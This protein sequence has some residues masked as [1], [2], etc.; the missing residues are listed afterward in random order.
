VLVITLGAPSGWAG[1][2]Q[3]IQK[4]GS[5]AGAID[6]A[7]A[8]LFDLRLSGP[9]REDAKGLLSYLFSDGGIN[10]RLSATPLLAP[11]L[12]SR[13]HR[14][15]ASQASSIE[16]GYF[17]GFVTADGRRFTPAAGARDKT[18][19][20]L[21][22]G[23]SEVP[24][25]AL[26]LQAAGKGFIVAEG[27]AGDASVVTTSRLSLGEG[28]EAQVRLTELIYE[29]GS[30]GFQ[31]DR[32]LPA[33][34]LQGQESEGFRA[35]LELAL[36]PRPA[37]RGRSRVPVSTASRFDEAYPEPTFPPL[38]YRLLAAFR[39]HNIIGYFFPYKDLMGEDWDSVLKDFIPR[40]EQA[41]DATEYHL[42]V[43]EM[44]THVHDSHGFVASRV[45][46]DYFGAARPPVVAR[47]IED[48]PV[49]A[50]FLDERA[51][52]QAGAKIGD[53]ILKVDGEDAKDRLARIGRYTDAST[54]QYR[55]QVAARRLMDGPEGSTAVVTIRD[56]KDH[57]KEIRLPRQG[58]YYYQGGGWRRGPVLRVLPGNI[59]YADLDRLEESEVDGMFEKFRRTRAIIFDDRG[60]PKGTAWAIAPRLTQASEVVAA[61]FDRPL[62]LEPEGATGDV[63]G[64]AARDLFLQTLP[65]TDKWR[66]RGR[67]V[68]LIDERTIS[69]AEHTGL[70][71]EA[72]NGTKFVGSPTAGAN[73]DVTNFTVPGGITINFSGQGVRHADG[74]QL[75]R[76][77]LVPDLE[78]RPT[79]AGI[80]AG[81]DEVL[82]RALAYVKDDLR[83][84]AESGGKDPP[85]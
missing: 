84:S 62:V 74:R 80:R 48:V 51:A 12:R 59:G 17:S 1:F 82:E 19:V 11:G 50:L 55:M 61:R 13:M 33:P 70:F 38:E 8:V 4:V 5:L 72:A 44:M 2:V 52:R 64:Q 18:T 69:Q 15:F 60:Y 67:T 27:S 83:S 10:G 20:F 77:G 54:P 76:I 14:G 34:R 24:P 73:G 68:L 39:I 47:M 42:A 36:H 58:K 78:V 30:V 53:V 26:A 37:E 56:T 49:I 32:V 71:F 3:A 9:I 81:R 7:Q 66:Y 63:T 75:Q 45:L 40:M 28:I 6:G 79:I 43:A 31:A 35:S 21:I 41:R 22:N 29:D 23:W 46:G 65:P 85:R 57:V 16:N 25:V